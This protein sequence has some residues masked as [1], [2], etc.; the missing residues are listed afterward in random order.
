M[1][2]GYGIFTSPLL[3]GQLGRAATVADTSTPIQMTSAS[4]VLK[5]ETHSP[6]I[7]PE[8]Y[9]RLCVLVYVRVRL[10][11]VQDFLK[12]EDP[13]NACLIC[14]FMDWIC[15]YT[16]GRYTIKETLSE[17]AFSIGLKIQY[18]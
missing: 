5:L 17:C 14:T 16:S 12:A 13:L 18:F 10:I 8:E 9:L 7:F 1:P 15:V 6:N 11:K 3:S 2:K 4:I